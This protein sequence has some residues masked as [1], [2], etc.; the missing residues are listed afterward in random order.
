[1]K[2]Y[3]GLKLGFVVNAIRERYIYHQFTIKLALFFIVEYKYGYL[4]K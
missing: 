3:V 2:V 1:M 4:H